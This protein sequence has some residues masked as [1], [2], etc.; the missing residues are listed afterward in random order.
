MHHVVLPYCICSHQLLLSPSMFRTT[1]HEVQG[2]HPLVCATHHH[3]ICGPRPLPLPALCGMA[4]SRCSADPPRRTG[5]TP[6]RCLWSFSSFSW[7][8]WASTFSVGTCEYTRR[9]LSLSLSLLT[10][11]LTLHLHHYA[12]LLDSRY[13]HICSLLFLLLV[14]SYGIHTSYQD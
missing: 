9:A 4:A 14:F 8:P 5:S 6:A 11:S 10:H 3:R 2:Q 12:A 13:P 1:S 7:C